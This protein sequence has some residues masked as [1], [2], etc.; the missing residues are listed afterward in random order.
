MKR[1]PLSALRAFS[2]VYDAGGVRPAARALGVTHSSVIRHLRELEGWLG[3]AL[4]TPGGR[5]GGLTSQGIALGKAAVGGLAELE[6]ALG[7][8]RELR[9]PHSVVL[10]T[11]ASFAARWLIPRMS[12]LARSQPWVELSITTDSSVRSLAEQGADLAVRMGAGPWQEDG[13]ELLASDELFPVAAPNYLRSLGAVPASRLLAKAR[14]LHDRDPATAWE[15]WFAEHAVRGVDLR[16]GPRFTSSDLVL[17]AAAQGL[18][19]AL[20]RASFARDE[21]ASGRLVRIG[22]E[23]VALPRAYWLVRENSAEPRPA[24]KA[25]IYWLKD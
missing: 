1:M 5:R 8:V 19:V 6:R 20:A 23:S 21:L 7:A 22:R 16:V 12:K 4:F 14:L 17:D 13:A 25:V 3:V 9:A 10:A 15:R 2:A 11:T 24:L 18:G